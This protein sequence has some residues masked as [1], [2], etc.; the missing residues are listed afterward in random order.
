MDRQ[1]GHAREPSSE[2][3]AKSISSK[4]F[5]KTLPHLLFGQVML[6]ELSVLSDACES[7]DSSEQEVDSTDVSFSLLL[8]RFKRLEPFFV[9]SLLHGICYILIF[10][11]RF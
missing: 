10:N 6:C 1:Y 9:F 2:G 3:F 7:S 8:L 11:K 4:G 5:S